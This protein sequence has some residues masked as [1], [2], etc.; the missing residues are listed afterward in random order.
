MRQRRSVVKLDEK[1]AAEE[2]ETGGSAIA[3][4]AAEQC[5]ERCDPGSKT[6]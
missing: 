1:K 4:G 2:A 5:W 6:A 3:R